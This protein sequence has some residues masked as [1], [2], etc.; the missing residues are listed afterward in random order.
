MTT[1][2]VA[3]IGGGVMGASVAYHL[4]AFGWRDILILDRAAGPG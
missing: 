1:A 4:A 3:V 2:S